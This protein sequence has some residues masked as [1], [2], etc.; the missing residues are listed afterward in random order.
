MMTLVEQ[1][2]IHMRGQC[3]RGGDGTGDLPLGALVVGS[4]ERRQGPARSTH[5]A[6]KPIGVLEVTHSDLVSEEP[7]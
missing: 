3:D 4:D 6:P 2:Y 7:S 1:A 5:I